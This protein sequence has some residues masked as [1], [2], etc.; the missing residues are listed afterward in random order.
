VVLLMDIRRVP[1]NEEGNFIAWLDQYR[2]ATILVLTKADKL[3]KTKQL[4]QQRT[5]AE[6]LQVNPDTLI[7]FS[8]KT[9]QGKAAVWKAIIDLL[10]DEGGG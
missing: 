6:A 9:R 10:P 3:S 7:R 4:R 2:L 1:G 8:A 5:V